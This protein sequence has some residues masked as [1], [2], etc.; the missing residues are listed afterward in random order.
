MTEP[1]FKALGRWDTLAVGFV[2]RLPGIGAGPD[3]EDRL[4]EATM[5]R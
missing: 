4:V 2:L 1:G 3:A 5:P